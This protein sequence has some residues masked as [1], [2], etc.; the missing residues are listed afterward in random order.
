LPAILGILAL[1]SLQVSVALH[2]FE[3]AD[4]HGLTVCQL[5]SAYSQ[6]ENLAADSI[7]TAELQVNPD[8]FHGYV[9]E[10]S[11]PVISAVPYQPRAPPL[12]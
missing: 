6:L 4:S 10:Q 8:S 1:A 11:V 7:A 2:Q 5:C 3:H 12:S 9:A